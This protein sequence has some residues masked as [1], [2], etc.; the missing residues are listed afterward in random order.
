MKDEIQRQKT[1]LKTS[2]QQH[3]ILAKD[4]ITKLEGEEEKQKYL[5]NKLQ[6][7]NDQNKA[8]QRMLE[9]TP[10]QNIKPDF[11][12]EAENKILFES[13]K[14]ERDAKGKI[15]TSLKETREKLDDV[16]KE[17]ESLVDELF[18]EKKARKDATRECEDV[19]EERKRLDT[20]LQRQC[21]AKEE[22]QKSLDEVSNELK[23][24]NQ[25]KTRLQNSFNDMV[26]TYDKEKE[27]LED[28]IRDLLKEKEKIPEQDF[29]VWY[30]V[31]LS[32]SGVGCKS[33]V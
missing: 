1:L 19:K 29:E 24:T 10:L 12:Q 18:V 22:L 11:D 7:V 28:R 2:Q 32:L 6:M 14:N 30:N 21:T 16:L 26:S 17:K 20:E 5:E 23:Y 9:E 33:H 25:M 15:E 13:L 4:L 31:F 3:D 27:G 8:L